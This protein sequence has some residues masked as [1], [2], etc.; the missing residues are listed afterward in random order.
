MRNQNV[1]TCYIPNHLIDRQTQ[2]P[3]FR[4]IIARIDD[5]WVCHACMHRNISE[6][7]SCTDH[8]NVSYHLLFVS[9][10]APAAHHLISHPSRSLYIAR[11]YEGTC[12]ANMLQSIA[13][14]PLRE[15]NSETDYFTFLHYLP[16][17]NSSIQRD[18]VNKHFYRDIKLSNYKKMCHENGLRGN[19]NEIAV[20]QS[21]KYADSFNL[22][23]DAFSSIAQKIS[24]SDAWMIENKKN[25]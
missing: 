16:T 14:D 21:F 7:C 9:I 15:V 23:F 24:R 25:N 20:E 6:N 4:R 10:I 11:T 12:P 2:T 19:I 5:A 3:L 18:L 22:W 17:D 1:K 8:P 13:D